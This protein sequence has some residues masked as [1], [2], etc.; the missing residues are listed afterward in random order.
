MT[1]LVAAP[2]DGGKRLGAGYSAA[3]QQAEL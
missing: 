2:G 1:L 3:Y